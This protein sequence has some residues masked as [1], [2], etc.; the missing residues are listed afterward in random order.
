[1]KIIIIEICI[2]KKNL[3][4][5]SLLINRTV[6]NRKGRRNSFQDIKGHWK[7]CVLYQIK[8]SLLTLSKHGNKFPLSHILGNSITPWTYYRYSVAEHRVINGR[9]RLCVRAFIHLKNITFKKS[10]LITAPVTITSVRANR[11]LLI[12]LCH[13]TQTQRHKHTC[14][15]TRAK[16]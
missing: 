6:T 7:H 13:H 2:R 8:K 10:L 14:A 16:L 1:M 3:A 12:L 15:E 11:A 4:L 5:T 9:E